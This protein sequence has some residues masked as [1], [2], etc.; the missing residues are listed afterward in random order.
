MNRRELIKNTLLAAGAVSAKGA[1]AESV[2]PK[3]EEGGGG[4]RTPA[5]KTSQLPTKR[6]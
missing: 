4:R 1:V 6:R 2:L 3:Q 5:E